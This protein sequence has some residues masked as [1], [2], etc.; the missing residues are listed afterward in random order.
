MGGLQSSAPLNCCR[1]STPTAPWPPHTHILPP[2][3]PPPPPPRM[4]YATRVSTIKN[5]VSKHENSKEMLK[6]KKMIDYWKEQAGLPPHKRDYVDLE[7]IEGGW[8]GGWG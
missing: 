2:P 7:E 4:Q 8:A 3:P 5:D 6:M 1:P